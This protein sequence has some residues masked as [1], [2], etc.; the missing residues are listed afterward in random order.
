MLIIN[1]LSMDTSALKSIEFDKCVTQNLFNF[2]NNFTSI[3]LLKLYKIN[4][5][6][7]YVKKSILQSFIC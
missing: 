4:L 3:M 2:I 6:Y 1:I 7:N 5:Y